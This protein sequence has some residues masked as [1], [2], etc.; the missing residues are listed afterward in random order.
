MDE[1]SEAK[2][3]AEFDAVYGSADKE[4]RRSAFSSGKRYLSRFGATPRF[5][6]NTEKV[7][8]EMKYLECEFDPSLEC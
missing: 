2:M 7:R 6:N 4:T 8:K 1:D 3:F 5:S